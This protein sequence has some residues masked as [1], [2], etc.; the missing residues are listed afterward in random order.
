MLRMKPSGLNG[1]FRPAV[2]PE[3][4]QIRPEIL[5]LRLIPDA[6][7]GFSGAWNFRLGI[8]DILD[9]IALAPG[10]AAFLVC[11]RIGIA[12]DSSAFATL[13]AIKLW[14]DL[15]FRVNADGMT[16]KASRERYL[17]RRDVL[18]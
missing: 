10:K 3:L 14:P 11:D 4:T 16:A 12:F 15:V 1:L 8:P 7:N 18:G 5:R 2:G 13:E 9:K 6:G 17:A